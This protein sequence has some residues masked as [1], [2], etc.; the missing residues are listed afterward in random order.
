MKKCELIESIQEQIIY[1]KKVRHDYVTNRPE[2]DENN[3]MSPS[4][5]EFLDEHVGYREDGIRSKTNLK[6]K[7][8]YDLK[9]LI[10]WKGSKRMLLYLFELLIDSKLI[11]KEHNK[12]LYATI[13]KHFKDVDT[14]AMDNKALQKQHSNMKWI[15]GY[16]KPKDDD[17]KSIEE[18]IKELKNTLKDLQDK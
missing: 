1:L 7:E 15:D 16:K 8:Q 4:L 13:A 2:I 18:I 3:F 6:I 17:A 5:E 9:D 11:D 10:W 12:N 14:R